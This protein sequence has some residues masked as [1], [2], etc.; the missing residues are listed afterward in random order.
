MELST[1]AQAPSFI[2]KDAGEEEYS[3]K[4]FQGSWLVLYFYP[5]DNTPGCTI[6]A[7]DFTR[8]EKDFKQL[9]ATVIGISPDSCASHA[10][11]IEKKDLNVLL[12]SDPDHLVADKYSVWAPKKFMG[13]EFLGIKRSTFIIDPKGTIVEAMYSVSAKGHAEQVLVKLK[14]LAK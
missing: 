10:R 4:D 13:R 6:E 12:L 14:E 9:G 2:L 5:K 11:F 3:L 1:G 7:M 8:L